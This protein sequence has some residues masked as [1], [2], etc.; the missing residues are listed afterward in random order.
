MSFLPLQGWQ[1]LSPLARRSIVAIGLVSL[2]TDLSSE[3]IFP[4]LPVFLTTALGAGPLSLGLIEGL[5]DS[6]SSL[7]K[8]ASGIFSDRTGR[9]KPFMV[10]GYTLSSLCKPFIGLAGSWPMALVLRFGDR[11]GKGMR[12]SPRDALIS[13]LIP[14]RHWGAAFGFHRAMDNLGAVLGPLVAAGLLALGFSLPHLFLLALV[15]GVLVVAL[16]V[17]GVK[18]IPVETAA[19]NTPPRRAVTWREGWRTLGPDYRKFLA[20]LFLFTLGEASEVFLLL[21]LGNLGVPMAWVAGL[22]AAH[23]AVRSLS[24]WRLGPLSDRVGRRPLVLAGW[25]LFVGVFVVFALGQGPWLP[26]L[27]FVAYGLSFGLTEAPQRA[28]VSDMVPAGLRGTAF[29]FYHGV[30]GLATLPA[31]VLFGAVWQGWGYQ[32]AFLMSAGVGALA[33]VLLLSVHMAGGKK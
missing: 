27:A 9:R 18:E 20:V 13:D 3:M 1:N 6:V 31:S 26:A 7:L 4:L 16:V 8:V 25:G 28:W 21:H 10:A 17:W 33:L 32:T 15:P 22:W 24:G 29:G 30:L 12:A 23:N 11:L 19:P 2:F 14:S 5:A